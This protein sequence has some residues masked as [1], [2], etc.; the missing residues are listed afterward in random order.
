M[1]TVI[2]NSA[3]CLEWEPVACPAVI[4]QHHPH[5]ERAHQVLNRRRMLPPYPVLD[6]QPLNQAELG[7]VLDRNLLWIFRV[8]VLYETQH[9]ALGESSSPSCLVQGPAMS[10]AAMYNARCHY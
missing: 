10:V 5:L 6:K 4:N 7:A 1:E 3:S 2:S 8:D 9:L